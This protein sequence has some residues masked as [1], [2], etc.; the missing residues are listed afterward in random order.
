MVWQARDIKLIRVSLQ[1][2][3]YG[4]FVH[5]ITYSFTDFCVKIISHAS[6]DY[7]FLVWILHFRKDT[8]CVSYIAQVAFPGIKVPMESA[9]K[10]VNLHVRHCAVVSETWCISLSSPL[11]CCKPGG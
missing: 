8:F 7:S 11:L 5:I 9:F 1:V 10:V 2:H 6:I 3:D 4:L